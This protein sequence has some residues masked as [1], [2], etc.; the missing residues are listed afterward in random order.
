MEADKA[1]GVLYEHLQWDSP[2]FDNKSEYCDEEYCRKVY[3]LAKN[4]GGAWSKI[5]ITKSALSMFERRQRMEW[6]APDTVYDA[7]LVRKGCER[8]WF[9]TH[10]FSVLF[11]D[12]ED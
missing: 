10:L 6:A 4:V 7:W 12:Y 2:E 5:D 1:E 9:D 8:A 11:P 3:N